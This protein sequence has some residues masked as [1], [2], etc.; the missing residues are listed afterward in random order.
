MTPRFCKIK[1]STRMSEVPT[2]EAEKKKYR[3]DT[4]LVEEYHYDSLIYR[5]QTWT[6]DSANH[7]YRFNKEVQQEFLNFCCKLYK[8][9]RIIDIPTYQYPTD[10]CSGMIDILGISEIK[11]YF[12]NHHQLESFIF[13]LKKFITVFCEI[14]E[15]QWEGPGWYQIS[16]FGILGHM[17]VKFIGEK[18]ENDSK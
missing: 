3:V 18:A 10:S 14:K 6:R 11:G 17:T 12:T 9:E 2:T 7:F 8:I 16:K 5:D 13:Y 1:Q 4:K 15:H